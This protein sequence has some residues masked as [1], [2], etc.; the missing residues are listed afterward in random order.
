MI[1]IFKRKN[2]D[3]LEDLLNANVSYYRFQNA[4]INFILEKIHDIG[5]SEPNYKIKCVFR[6]FHGDRSDIMGIKYGCRPEMY[7]KNVSVAINK[8]LTDAYLFPGTNEFERFDLFAIIFHELNHL[9][10]EKMFIDGKCDN[11]NLFK[12]RALEKYFLNEYGHNVYYTENYENCTEEALCNIY[13]INEAIQFLKEN[14]IELTDE[15]KSKLK[16]KYNSYC[17]KLMDTSRID[18]N[19]KK[20]YTLDE[21]YDKY[22]L[23]NNLKR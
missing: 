21:L 11:Q 2:N 19:D 20:K 15:E 10:I 23:G 3:R 18:P 22:I 17:D 13:G 16:E 4:L 7:D 5:F 9:I 14:N 12:D 6:D 8:K 1:N